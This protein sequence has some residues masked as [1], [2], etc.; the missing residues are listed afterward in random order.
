MT[1][2]EAPLCYALLEAYHVGRMHSRSQKTKVLS[3]GFSCTRAC[4]KC[5]WSPRVARAA[6][7]WQ[8]CVFAHCCPVH[9]ECSGLI[10]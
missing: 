5:V 1:S 3:P 6:R 2:S 10:C 9:E 7:G 4:L 8:R